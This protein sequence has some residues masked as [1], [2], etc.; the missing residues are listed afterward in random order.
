MPLK[1]G[2]M[3]TREETIEAARNRPTLGIY[4][5]NNCG[6][7]GNTGMSEY[8]EIVCLSCGNVGSPLEEQFSE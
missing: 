1:S 2:N 3:S 7:K 5:C 6:Q 8:F 4:T